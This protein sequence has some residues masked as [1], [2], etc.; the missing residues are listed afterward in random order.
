VRVRISAPHE[1]TGPLPRHAV[2]GTAT[3]L[4]GNHVVAQTRLL[5]AKP[6]PAVS[7]LSIAAGFIFQPL[8]LLVIVLL[9][10]GGLALAFHLRQRR[11]VRGKGGLEPA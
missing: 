11:R 8:T 4:V 10:G 7:P 6:L 2:L 9:A 3:V 5:L 1:L